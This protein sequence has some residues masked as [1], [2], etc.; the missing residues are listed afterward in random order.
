METLS[1]PSTAIALAGIDFALIAASTAYF[2]NKIGSIN[3]RID[4]LE[5]NKSSK[6]NDD[7]VDSVNDIYD[8]VEFLESE[9]EKL[10]DKI[11]RL[12][13]ITNKL[14]FALNSNNI[15]VAIEQSTRR[16][17]RSKK[18]LSTRSKSSKKDDDFPKKAPSEHDQDEDV[19][20]LLNEVQI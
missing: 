2:S 4:E 3:T 5:K 15:P 20:A 9:N 8:R 14:L 7:I 18:P 1:K 19:L 12:E 6:G 16:I 10:K 11:A 13:H 17:T